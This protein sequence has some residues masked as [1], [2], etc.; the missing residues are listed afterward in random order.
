M[1]VLL[2]R[3]PEEVAAELGM[4]VASVHQAKARISRTLKKVIRE[5]ENSLG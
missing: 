1:Y 2:E 3:P 5:L 4:T